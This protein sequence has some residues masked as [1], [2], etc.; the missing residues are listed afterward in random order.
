MA[1]RNAPRPPGRPGAA[2]KGKPEG[3]PGPGGIIA[4]AKRHPGPAALAGGA[5]ALGVWWLYKRGQ[6]ANA[7][8]GTTDTSG[9]TTSGGAPADFSGYGWPGTGTGG[10]D[11]AALSA[12]QDQLKQ[13]LAAEDKGSD[14]HRPP[15]RHRR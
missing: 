12:I 8:S 15:R 13:L 11:S 9:A 6:S 10:N 1:A 5:G 2:G 7:T 3:L 4:W 14:H